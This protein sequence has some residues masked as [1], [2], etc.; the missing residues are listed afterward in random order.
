MKSQ[1]RTQELSFGLKQKITLF[2]LMAAVG[3]TSFLISCSPAKFDKKIDP[4]VNTGGNPIDTLIATTPP[5][6]GSGGGTTP[7]PTPTPSPSPQ[8]SMCGGPVDGSLYHTG[9]QIIKAQS[10][11]MFSSFSDCQLARQA[12]F[13]N[14]MVC[15]KAVAATIFG[16]LPSRDGSVHVLE[17]DFALPVFKSTNQMEIPYVYYLHGVPNCEA[18][19]NYLNTFTHN[20]ILTLG[21]YTDVSTRIQA[22][23]ISQTS[24]R[25]HVL[26]L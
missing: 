8:S 24:V 26:G 1:N 2:H 14:A 18:A 15:S 5:G 4:P 23:C 20:T 25:I 9:V 21:N 16:C 22:E 6:G 19:K 11:Q 10:T 13:G 7:T 12:Y 3:F 17:A